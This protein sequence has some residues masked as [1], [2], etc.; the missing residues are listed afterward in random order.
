[1]T[2]IRPTAL[3]A[4][5]AMLAAVAAHRPAGLAAAPPLA[6]AD[7]AQLRKLIRPGEDEDPFA[8][9]PWETSLWEARR[10]AAAGGKPV[11]LWEMDGHPLGCG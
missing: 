2:R 10:K 5:A 8:T 6:D 9:I 1:M 7:L 3:A 11:L 4:L